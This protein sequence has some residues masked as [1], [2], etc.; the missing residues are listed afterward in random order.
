MLEFDNE[1]EYFA[2]WE[3]IGVFSTKELAE[4]FQDLHYADRKRY[5][6]NEGKYS[7]TEIDLDP[8]FKA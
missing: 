5:D 2:C 1:G 8:K 6:F 7:I 3:A 4:E